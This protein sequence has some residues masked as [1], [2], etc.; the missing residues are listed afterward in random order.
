MCT[1]IGCVQTWKWRKPDGCHPR[2]W[3]T[4][5]EIFIPDSQRWFEGAPPAGQELTKYQ[6]DKKI[7]LYASEVQQLED[8]LHSCARQYHKI[9]S[10]LNYAQ[11]TKNA[12][13]SFVGGFGIKITDAI[14]YYKGIEP[15]KKW[16]KY[17]TNTI[18]RFCKHANELL[19]FFDH[20]FRG[21]L[22]CTTKFLEQTIKKNKNHLENVKKYIEDEFIQKTNTMIRNQRKNGETI[23]KR[24]I[25]SM[26]SS[27]TVRQQLS[28]RKQVCNKSTQTIQT[29][30][31]HYESHNTCTIICS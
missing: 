28:A 5:K 27:L 14:N 8:E 16:D 29:T 24:A 12:L 10:K 17:C 31:V 21:Q 22:V 4:V 20:Q 18:R 19:T 25:M 30:H 23:V 7:W 15:A 6:Q 9:E 1:F 26:M 11:S 3:C 13:S 2:S